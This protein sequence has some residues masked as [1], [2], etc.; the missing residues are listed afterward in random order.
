VSAGRRFVRALTFW[1]FALVAGGVGV[2]LIGADGPAAAA[3]EVA[4]VEARPQLVTAED[5]PRP[6]AMVATQDRPHALPLSIE[7]RPRPVIVAAVDVQREAIDAAVTPITSVRAPDVDCTP[8]DASGYRRG[9]KTPITIVKIDGEPIE[10]ATA[11][12][13]LAMHEAAAADGV[14]LTIFSAF[15]SPEQQEYFYECFKTCACNS[16]APAAKPG[17]SNHQMGRAVDIAMWPG[18]H[19]WLVANAK[20]FGF[21]ATVKQEPWH[22]ELRRGA[23]PPKASVCASKRG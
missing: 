1:A 12:A 22:W 4:V 5:R 15:R 6:A 14:D 21:V 9:R 18:V 11:N 7:D 10:R 16:C 20:R 17:F 3:M 13:Y 2:K 19:E 8:V 23:K